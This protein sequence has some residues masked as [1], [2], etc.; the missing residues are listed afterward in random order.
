MKN[1]FFFLALLIFSACKNSATDTLDQESVTYERIISLKG[2]YTEILFDLGLS[3]K[4]VG[5]D[6]TSAYPEAARSIESVGHISGV[7]ASGLASL[8]PDLVLYPEGELSADI[9]EQ[10]SALG[11]KTIGLQQDYS[12]DG[13]KSL[14]RQIAE[15]TAKTDVAKSKLADFDK[16]IALFKASKNNLS[17]CFI[18]ARGAGTLM[19]GGGNTPMGALIN[20][21]GAKNPFEDYD[22]FVP[23][24][25]EAMAVANPDVLFVFESGL[26]SLG[27]ASGLL[28]I[29][30]V[31]LTKAAKSKQIVVMDGSLV[32]HFA[33]RLPQA[34]I[35]LQNQL[36]T[37]Q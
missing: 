5:V 7:T 33:L 37:F 27:G 10:L 34:L 32:S 26:Q 12:V 4:I 11:I 8:N 22:G 17:V 3:S 19:V 14:I 21:V 16:E 36:Q 23:L 28:S 25:S 31:S 2:V 18:Y 9:L 13:A 35:E 6:V 29:E 30:G 24:N 1:L 20:L 15:I